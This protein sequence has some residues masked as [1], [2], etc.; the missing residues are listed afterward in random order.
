[1]RR[2]L[3]Q[4]VDENYIPLLD[5]SR[6]NHQ[7]YCNRYD[8]PY[9]VTVGV[10]DKEHTAMWNKIPLIIDALNAGID[11]IVLV[12]A[13]ALIVD[14]R[15][16]IFDVIKPGKDVY[17]VAYDNMKKKGKSYRFH[18]DGVMYINNTRGSKKFFNWCWDHRNHK[19]N[20]PPFPGIRD[21][22]YT[23]YYI[24]RHPKIVGEISE[25]YNYL[26][27]AAKSDVNDAIVKHYAGTYGDC[28]E[29]FKN[30]LKKVK[31]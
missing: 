30:D 27:R 4:T 15:E 25:R 3:I 7:E 2:V 11:Q 18:N 28:V 1:M 5:L 19:I 17:M 10:M 8:I 29:A 26:T 16:N 12:D 21:N 6:P 23:A 9:Q 20:S 13:D 22:Q 24:E 14:H 31:K